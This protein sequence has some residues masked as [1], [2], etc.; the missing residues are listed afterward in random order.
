M[1]KKT[2]AV[3]ATQSKKIIV[4]ASY[5]WCFI[6]YRTAK[7]EEQEGFVELYDASVIR[8]WGT[9]AGIGELAIKGP[10][11]DTVLD[12]CGFVAIP[13]SSVVSIVSC[14]ETA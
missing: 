13:L 6:G 5:G 11:G 2:T 8:V 7:Q 1:T 3:R 12:P 9:T 4:I 14:H 10:T